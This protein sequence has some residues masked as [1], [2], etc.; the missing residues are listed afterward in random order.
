MKPV[1]CLCPPPRLRV[2][3]DRSL[4]GGGGT[5]EPA[6]PERQSGRASWR[7]L[8]SQHGSLYS[9]KGGLGPG[10]Q[11]GQRHY[12]SREN[13]SHMMGLEKGAGEGVRGERMG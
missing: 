8:P 9:G 7:R 6:N 12:T 5:E 3:R 1:P 4:E 11:P 10:K 13:A 2:P